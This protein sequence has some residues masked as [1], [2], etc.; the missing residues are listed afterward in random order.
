MTGI[1]TTR[2]A[3]CIARYQSTIPG[4]AEVGKQFENLISMFPPPTG[5]RGRVGGQTSAASPPPQPSPCKGE[6]V[7][8]VDAL[9]DLYEQCYP[10]LEQARWT[11][12]SDFAP[13]L[14]C[15]QSLFR[16]Q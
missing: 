16:G 2:L 9:I 14:D 8:L 3:E 6:G 11:G 13:L 10:L 4:L 5:G 1:D 15:Y 7:E 12:A